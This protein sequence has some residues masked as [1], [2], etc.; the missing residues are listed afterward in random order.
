MNISLYLA[1][2]TKKRLKVIN[3]FQY[4]LFYYIF[5]LVCRGN[6]TSKYEFPV[7]VVEVEFV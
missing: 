5:L 2:N 7:L 1:K 6:V 4:S 3:M